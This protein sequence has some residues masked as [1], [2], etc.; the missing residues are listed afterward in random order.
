MKLLPSPSISSSSTSTSFHS[1]MC[2]SRSATASCLAGILRRLFCSRSLPTHPSDPIIDTTS[3]LSH[4]KQQD[5]INSTDTSESAATAP[6]IV[7]RLMGLESFQDDM[8]VNGCSISRSRS[9]NSVE[10]NDQKR[11]RYK[12]AK[13]TLSFC[14]MP[15]FLEL[16]NEEFLVLSFEE[17]GE[18]K[19]TRSRGRKYEVGFEEFRE[20][21]REK[22]KS[23]GSTNDNVQVLLKKKKIK[24]KKNKD[25]E[26]I[27]N[28]M[29]LK[30]LNEEQLSKGSSDT[31]AQEI[32][33]IEDSHKRTLPLKDSCEKTN[34]ASVLQEAKESHWKNDKD[35]QSG[36]QLTKKKKKINRCELKNEEREECSSEDWSPVSVLEF[37]QFMVD[38]ELLLSGF[39][40]FLS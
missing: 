23:K 26:A 1:N 30:I 8:Q 28:K 27:I 25:D 35:V 24:K 18:R 9:M 17:T 11:G 12:R 36:P 22:C 10:V 29:V 3:V 34:A 33:K 7:A 38:H 37:D 21:T 2:T 31:D 13:S 32:A 39:S 4:G 15:I 16:E 14:E 5:F 20:K 40:S 6:G 19:E